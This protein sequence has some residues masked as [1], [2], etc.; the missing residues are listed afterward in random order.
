MEDA[1]GASV[2]RAL[3]QRSQ[4]RAWAGEGA[5]SWRHGGPG[6]EDCIPQASRSRGCILSSNKQHHSTAQG[7]GHGAR[8]C[9]PFHQL[10]SFKLKM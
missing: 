4:G 7:Q 1:Q 6:V 10:S 5:R 8:G 2:V 3:Q 9:Q